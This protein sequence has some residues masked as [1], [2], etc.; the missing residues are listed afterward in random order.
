MP[1]I[2]IKGQIKLKNSA[3][4]IV[5]A[6]G[7]G[8]PAALYLASAGVGHIG[9]IDYDDIEINNLHRQLLYTESNIGIS[10]ANAAVETLNRL[11]STIKV[12]PY[13]IQLDSN[14][15]LDIIKSYD[16]ILDATDNVATRYLLNDACVLNNKPLVSGSALK[17]EGH[18]SVFNYNGPCYR[19]IFP[20]PPPPETVTNCGD[21]G[22]FGPAVGTIGILQALEAL[23][24][25]LDLPCILSGQLLLFD[26][27]ETK[28]RNI[29]L[30]AKN[31]NCVVCG[32]HPTIH[33]LIDY[34]QFCGAKANDKNPNLNLLKK[35]ERISVEEYNI[36]KVDAKAHILIDVRSAEEFEICHLKNS[37]NI[38][39]NDINNDEKI[40]FIKNKI[41]EMQKQ[42]DKTTL[43]VICRRGNDSQKAVINLQTVFKESNLEIKDIIGGIHAWSKKIDCTIPIY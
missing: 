41:Q 27:L 42:Y 40:N 15:A 5:G 14:N 43:Y 29:S 13:K 6:G 17:F 2:G 38:P 12:I 37:I 32:D 26:G 18:L 39:L 25:V 28:F 10:K 7:L 4:L 21:G 20:K 31:V 34:E 3:I 24:I 30:R 23:K 35:E 19:C 8:C 9:I 16:V 11:N 1:E 22:V 33:K 36:M